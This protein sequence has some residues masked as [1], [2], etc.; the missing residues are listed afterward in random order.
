[1]KKLFSVD[2]LLLVL[3]SS[4]SIFGQEY[5]DWKFTH[6]SPQANGLR[7]IKM[8]DANTWVTTG[9]NGTFMRTT[10]GGANWFFQCQT[11]RYSDAAQTIGINYNLW[12]FNSMNGYVTG[13]RGY[14]GKTTNGGNTFDSVGVGVIPTNEWGQGMW[15]ANQ[16][17][18]FVTTRQGSWTN[19]RIVRTTNGGVT[20]TT[21][22]TY[23]EGITSIWGTNSQTVYAVAVDGTIF[24]TTNAGQTWAQNVGVT[25]QYMYDMGFL[26]QTTGFVVGSQGGMAR[27]TNAGLTWIPLSS[28]QIDWAYFQIKI[29]SATEIYVVGDP[30]ALYKS[31]DLGNTWQTINIMPVSGP[32][33]TFIWY[34]M[35]KVGSTFVLCGDFGIVAKST[36]NGSTWASNN[37]LLNTNIL[38]DMAL[39]PGTNNLFAVGR[40]YSIGTRQVFYSSNYGTNWV[41]QDLG[42]DMNASSICMV[43]SQIGYISGTNCQVLKTTNG[44]VNWFQVT[45]PTSGTFDIYTIDFVTPDIGWVFVNY[46]A[47]SGGN[48]FKTTDGGV[49]WTQQAS[50]ITYSIS[51]ADMVDANIGYATINSSGQPI[52]KTT[53]GGTNWFSVT[54]P[55]NGIIRTVKA[56][57]ANTIYIGASNGTTRLAKSTNGGTNWSS[58]VLP[59]SFDVSSLDFVDADTGYVSGNS[60]TVV[61]RTTNGGTNWTFQNVH[62]PTLVGVKVLSN[63]IAFVLGTYGSIMRYDPHSFVPVE[64]ISF[65]SSASGNNVLL[66]W[67]TTTEL[68]NQGFDV[69][70]ASIPGQWEKIGFVTG[71]GTTTEKRSYIYE[72]NALDPGT[73]YYRLKQ[74][75]YD[76]SFEYSDEIEVEITAPFNFVLEQNYPNPFNP[77]TKIKYSVPNDGLVNIAIYNVL[78]EKVADLVNTFQKT[79]HHE[80]DFNANE[81]ASGLYMYRM[82]AG[83]FVSVKKMLLLK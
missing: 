4:F 25:P 66:K 74:I 59:V 53:N 51:S 32:A 41:T 49:S 23:A 57:D 24:K 81:L 1:M 17:T 20:W 35:D 14:I 10:N 9:E 13:M 36:D 62:L 48:I 38:F 76:G 26:N 80:I 21:V 72:D 7:E 28:P 64:L 82:E 54:T 79:G 77:T 40:Q 58:I 12:F 61:C 8:I 68:N 6:P 16:D 39:A 43:N 34:S 31:T 27:T 44:G 78:G 46:V 67:N 19:G 18:G 33:S 42:I 22:Q 50:N 52:Y 45:Q 37:F 56:I 73:Y 29:I 63:D 71:S 5:Q 60:T 55:M 83:E 75:D 47:L 69:E 30:T 65:T 70:R 15:F 2:L 11:G 3:L